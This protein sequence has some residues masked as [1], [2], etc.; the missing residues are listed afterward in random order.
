LTN[1][2]GHLKY[3]LIFLAGFDSPAG[4]ADKER[5]GR[6]GFEEGVEANE[7]LPQP[8]ARTT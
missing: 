6:G 5:A 2:W 7:I 3:L 4:K 1:P 8:G